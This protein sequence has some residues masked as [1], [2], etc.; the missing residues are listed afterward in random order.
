MFLSMLAWFTPRQYPTSASW[1]LL[2]PWREPQL[3]TLEFLR[4]EEHG[5]KSDQPSARTAVPR[6]LHSLHTQRT[7]GHA[8]GRPTLFLLQSAHLICSPLTVRLLS[9]SW[10]AC[11][12]PEARLTWPSA[13]QSMKSY[14]FL[15]WCKLA[16]RS[17]VISHVYSFLHFFLISS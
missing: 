1:Y 14:R 2:R 4:Y 12:P 3:C 11:T 7:G 6:R 16:N 17:V 5:E 13:L 8:D 15:L 9:C 10:Q